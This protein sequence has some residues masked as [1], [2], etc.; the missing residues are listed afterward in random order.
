[1]SAETKPEIQQ[2]PLIIFDTTLRDGEQSPGISLDTEEKLEIANQLAK[3]G[4]DYL[5]AG[6]PVASQ[7]DFEAVSA[8][9]REV[10]GPVI[11]GLTRTARADVDRCWDALQ[12]ADNSRIHVFIATSPNHMKNKLKMTPDQV[13]K[14]AGEAVRYAKQYTDDVEFSP[15]D[16]SRS[17]FDFMCEVLQIAVDNGA[18]TLNIPDTVGW[19]MPKEYEQRFRSIRERVNGDYVLSAHCHDDLGG[20]TFNTLAAIEGGARQAE[21]A[22]NGI[23]ERAGNAA[24]EEVV[25]AVKTREDYFADK[26]GVKLTTNI[27]TGL[28]TATSKLVERLTGYEVPR[29]KAVVG[30]NAFAHE[31]G[32]HQHGMLED[33]STYEIMD[34]S[35]VGQGETTFVVGKHHGTHVIKELMDK[36]YLPAVIARDVGQ[37]C[38]TVNEETGRP[39]SDV[40]IEELALAYIQDEEPEATITLAG[41]DLN[42]QDEQFHAVI[43]LAFGTY[44]KI[45]ESD[46]GG[47][48]GAGIKAIQKEFPDYEFLDLVEAKSLKDNG[49]SGEG[50][51]TARV[52]VPIGEDGIIITTYAEDVSLD[53]AGIKAFI[54]AVNCGERMRKRA[55]NT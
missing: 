36:L 38:K 37:A 27:E 40:E 54:R 51:W 12:Y 23:G 22:I 15:E 43:S 42:T 17:D 20:A 48:V 19:T 30:R 14:E 55:K 21:V 29:N 49:A 39:L 10:K 2:K 3:L 33:S 34:P 7:G 47:G 50:G 28:L 26:L 32:I 11:T 24:L 52:R 44:V 31:A 6:F 41:V 1:M 18:T 25:M 53:R 45:V 46:N 13:K 16:A 4:V 8:I 9:A 5:E 35:V